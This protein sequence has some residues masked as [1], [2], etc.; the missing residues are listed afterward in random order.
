MT[1]TISTD[2]KRI[3][4]KSDFDFVA[5]LMVSAT[6]GTITD[7]GFPSYDW[8]MRIS[9]GCNGYTQFVASAKGGKLKNCVNDN[10]QLRIVCDNHGLRVGKLFAEFYAY[11]PND[12]YPDGEQLVV[13]PQEI[14]IEL[15]ADAGDEPTDI[16]IQLALPFIYDSAYRQAVSAGYKGTQEEYFALASQLPDAVEIAIEVGKKAEIISQSAEKIQASATTIDEGARAIKT[17]ADT[18]TSTANK[19]EQAAVKVEQAVESLSESASSLS[20]SATKLASVTDSATSLENSATSISTNTNALTTLISDWADGKAKIADALTRKYSPTETTESFDAMAQKVMDLPLAVEGQEGIIDHTANGI[21]DGYDLLNELHKH[22]RQDYPYCCGVEFV[23]YLYKTVV[24]SGAEAYLCCDGFFTTEQEVE[25]TFAEDNKLSH[26]IIYYYTYPTYQVPTTINPASHLIAYNG[27]PRFILSNYYCPVVQS[28]TNERYSVGSAE[29]GL[30]ASS[31]VGDIMLSGIETMSGKIGANSDNT[32]LYSI[33]LPHLKNL[34]SGGYIANKFPRLYNLSIPN[35][36][37]SSGDVAYGCNILTNLE[38]SSLNKVESGTI[39]QI[40]PSLLYLRLPNLTEISGGTI[41][42]SCSKLKSIELP[43]LVKSS[44]VII[45]SCT[46][47]ESLSIPN[48]TELNG[49][50]IILNSTKIEELIL[51]KLEKHTSGNVLG[52]QSYCKVVRLPKLVSASHS[53]S[54]GS[55]FSSCGKSGLSIDI[56]MPVITNYIPIS[57]ISQQV[58]FHL[59]TQQGCDIAF[60]SS[61]SITGVKIVTIEQGFRSSLN[62]SKLTS[63]TVESLQGIIDNLA[64]NNDYEPLTLTLGTTLKNKL[65][66]EYIAIATAKNYNIA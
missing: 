42:Y 17:N 54:S 55:L 20:D 6:D 23:P 66:E 24:L 9:S 62:V 11:L 37:F 22:Q 50:D 34:E 3:N 31:L 14:G 21:I 29:I 1:A 58:N 46:A 12:I 5:R 39:I 47:L 10:G 25:H 59:G 36:E 15:V 60:V 52:Y 30:D 48:L 28:Y 43:N 41:A 51:P 53:A 35:L 57:N 61:N 45:T 38:L 16:E 49:G 2:I 44:G 8:E 64:D 18:L 26:Y 32:A 33:S 65:S 63:L 4:Y 13:N 40:C 56:Y 19:V 27:Q 7:I